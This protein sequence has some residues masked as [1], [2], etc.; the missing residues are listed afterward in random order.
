MAKRK[1]IDIVEGNIKEQFRKTR[2]YCAELK[3]VDEAAMVNLKLNEDSDGLRFLH[4]QKGL[5]PAFES[6]FPDAKNRFCVR[7]LHNNMK[8]DGFRGIALKNALWAAAKATTVADFCQK[9][10][11]LKVIDEKA[12]KCYILDARGKAVIPMFESIQNFLM[13]RFQVNREWLRSGMKKQWPECKLTPPL[14]P[15][16]HGKVG[17]PTKLKR[18]KRD[19]PSASSQT[20][21]RGVIRNNKCKNCGE[22]GHN[23]STC[24][25]VVKEDQH[26][27][28]TQQIRKSTSKVGVHIE[29]GSIRNSRINVE[30]HGN[31]LGGDRVF[32]INGNG[33]S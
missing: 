26:E 5:I 30:D 8:N 22:Y 12:Y 11:E 23:K 32:V 14:P 4:K 10:E 29:G 27:Q 6:L 18:R 3:R 21:L 24:S 7:H 2:N 15:V 9:M 17:R 20:K 1:A 16:Y 13:V 19:K 25:S 33:G 28:A 31:W